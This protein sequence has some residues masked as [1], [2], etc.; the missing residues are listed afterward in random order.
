LD[1]SLPETF[2]DPVQLQQILLNLFM[3]AMDAMIATPAAERCIAVSTKSAPS[4]A[5]EV[6]VKDHGTGMRPDQQARVFEPFFTTKER[7]LGL[8]LAIC[9]TILQA[10]GG[11]LNLVN[12][13]AGG[14]VALLTLPASEM[15]IA[16]Q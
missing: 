16:A 12:D 4:G 11:K 13:P 8:G 9:T 5:V 14:A 7:G 10:H 3:N 2:G 6:R 1:G 15:L